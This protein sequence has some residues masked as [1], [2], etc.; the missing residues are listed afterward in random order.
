M[1]IHWWVPKFPVSLQVYETT[2]CSQIG[3][4]FTYSICLLT[5][6]MFCDCL[7]SVAPQ[8]PTASPTTT[9]HAATNPTTHGKSHSTA[10]KPRLNL[11]SFIYETLHDAVRAL[12]L[13]W[14]SFS[15]YQFMF[16]GSRWLNSVVTDCVNCIYVYVPTCVNS[17]HDV[18]Y[19]TH[20]IISIYF[21][22]SND[23]N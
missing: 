13:I 14:E 17:I 5:W 10:A 11:S 12:S 22:F 19:L 3:A 1:F 9:N 20:L 8:T 21:L 7:L 18:W 16:R 2:I 6:L 23:I 15:L 4:Y